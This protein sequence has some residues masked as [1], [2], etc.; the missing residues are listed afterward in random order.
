MKVGMQAIPCLSHIG[1]PADKASSLEVG[2]MFP[3]RG[4]MHKVGICRRWP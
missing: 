1:K 2:L 3:N 4:T